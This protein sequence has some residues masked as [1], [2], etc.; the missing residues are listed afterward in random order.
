[1]LVLLLL[2]L[3]QVAA[4]N[5][6]RER[7]E[8]AQRKVNQL[9]SNSLTGIL[10]HKPQQQ[11][12]QQQRYPYPT[13]SSPLS[14]PSSSPR[15]VPN[16]RPK[17]AG[18]GANAMETSSV[19]SPSRDSLP[20][21]CYSA[22]LAAGE[23]SYNLTSSSSSR[24]DAVAG[25]TTKLGTTQRGSRG[26]KMSDE[27]QREEE[28]GSQWQGNRADAQRVS[29]GDLE[30]M[31]LEQQQR[32][33]QPHK[34]KQ[35]REQVQPQQ[36]LLQQSKQVMLPHPF[37]LPATSSMSPRT[38]SAQKAA[39]IGGSSYEYS[40]GTVTQLHAGTSTTLPTAPKTPAR[41]SPHKLA[42]SSSYMDCGEDSA[43]ML[44]GAGAL[45][46]AA[47]DQQLLGASLAS[48][49]D[50]M[51]N[52]GTMACSG[53]DGATLEH[54][55]AI[56]NQRGHVRNPAGV[57][58]G[59]WGDRQ[60]DESY[61]VGLGDS[62]LIGTMP[63]N[64]CADLQR[65]QRQQQQDPQHFSGGFHFGV[66]PD[67]VEGSALRASTDLVPQQLQQPGLS[68]YASCS[69]ASA[70]NSMELMGGRVRFGLQSPSQPGGAFEV[71]VAAGMVSRGVWRDREG[72][73]WRKE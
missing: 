21:R 40:S 2:H 50:S 15:M 37:E 43:G 25:V 61:R 55:A 11:Q 59:G 6:T 26:T 71:E 72:R 68:V 38:A 51:V 30:A 1:M 27:E 36:L 20:V 29:Y 12:Q 65:H 34:Q 19:V 58:G 4:M 45:P 54:I 73:A 24:V 8:A 9:A 67:Q 66:S 28:D 23:G 22:G 70:L 3:L 57:G 52:F 13:N 42:A 41:G 46:A 7:Q 16:S 48:G 44:R 32:L 63:P 14:S 5:T 35:Q 53:S 62:V 60:E 10:A 17:S 56:A 69:L 47:A 18:S 64:A 33:L 31:L 49:N 39:P